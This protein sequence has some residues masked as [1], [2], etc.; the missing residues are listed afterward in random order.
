M[1]TLLD[2]YPNAS[3]DA[4]AANPQLAGTKV[5]TLNQNDSDA[6]LKRVRGIPNK[7]EREFGMILE[8]QKRN[9]EILRYEYEGITLRWAG[10]RYTPDFVVISRG[11]RENDDV[12][13]NLTFIEVKGA[14]IK[15]KFERAVER[16]R[17]AKTYWPEFTFELWQRQ[18]QG[19]KQL[20]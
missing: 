5:R 15:G 3:K 2:L 16:F 13:F 6:I 1:K 11:I 17:H 4:V 20:H 14:F 19:W 12:A 9:G 7:T 8:A 18:K 10:I